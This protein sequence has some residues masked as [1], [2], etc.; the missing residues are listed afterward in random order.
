METTCYPKGNTGD[1]S[2][3]LQL[4]RGGLRY[5]TRVLI[6]PQ[7]TLPYQPSHSRC[8]KSC[9][10]GIPC[11]RISQ[12]SPISPTHRWLPTYAI[13]QPGC[14]KEI[15]Q[16][17]GSKEKLPFPSR[18]LLCLP[19]STGRRGTATMGTRTT[20]NAIAATFGQSR[21]CSVLKTQMDLVDIRIPCPLQPQ[22]LGSIST[23]TCTAPAT[24][25]RISGSVSS[26]TYV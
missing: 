5:N 20:S 15:R 18:G 24:I 6:E 2:K 1:D 21:N 17:Q 22:D 26:S 14:E 11:C 8:G 9:L 4:G 16:A 23:D 12:P 10:V 3:R 19:L 25:Q 13:A 7:I